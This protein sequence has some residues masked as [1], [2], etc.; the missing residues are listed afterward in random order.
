[1]QCGG[2]ER[3]QLFQGLLRR[4][5]KYRADELAAKGQPATG[6]RGHSRGGCEAAGD[7][8]SRSRLVGRAPAGRSH[9]RRKGPRLA[10]RGAGCCRFMTDAGARDRMTGMRALATLTFLIAAILRSEEHTSELQSLMRNSY[11]V[12]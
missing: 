2:I 10:A 4:A 1:M 7:R 9:R 6:R 12:F 3:R 11:A 5:G 8:L